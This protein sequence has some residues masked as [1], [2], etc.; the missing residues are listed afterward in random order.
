MF[1]RGVDRMVAKVVRRVV[2]L[3]GWQFNIKRFDLCFRIKKSLELWLD[4]PYIENY[5]IIIDFCEKFEF[6]KK[7]GSLHMYQNQNEITRYFA[8]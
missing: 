3:W 7:T 6:V 2:G 5:K 8:R 4:M 1:R